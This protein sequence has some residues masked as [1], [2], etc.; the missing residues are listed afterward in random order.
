MVPSEESITD[1]RL[2]RIREA[3]APFVTAV[4]V[5]KKQ[6][7]KIGADWVWAFYGQNRWFLARVQAKKLDFA[8]DS[9]P[10]VGKKTGRSYQYNLLIHRALYADYRRRIPH[11][12]PLF[13][14]YCFYNYWADATCPTTWGCPSWQSD[15]ST[16]GCTIASAQAVRQVWQA[17]HRKASHF[18][19]ECIPWSCL[20]CHRWPPGD[21]KV[22]SS[23]TP[24]GPPLPDRVYQL[25]TEFSKPFALPE[26]RTAFPDVV[27][28]ILQGDGTSQ[29]D[30]PLLS[31]I[32]G[33]V[34]I[35]EEPLPEA[36]QRSALNMPPAR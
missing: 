26:P 16:L 5:N 34:V 36:I 12:W 10:G 21:G 19:P 14:M 15:P 31:N 8:S 33:V 30:R 32:E 20:F 3:A 13:P 29:R 2:L 25:L 17:G 4:R 35:G 6:E 22:P 9:Y 23:P 11:P 1:Y 24:Q 27:A 18:A 28:E 7:G